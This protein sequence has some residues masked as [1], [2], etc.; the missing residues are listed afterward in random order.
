[1]F[2]TYVVTLCSRQLYV[3]S[4]DCVGYAHPVTH[5]PEQTAQTSRGRSSTR[6][7][8]P[9]R[10]LLLGSQQ[11]TH[12]RN[13]LAWEM[14]ELE[15]LSRTCGYEPVAHETIT[16]AA[17]HAATLFGKGTIERIA[18]LI[19]QEQIAT[20]IVNDAL[21]PR[22]QRNLEEAWHVTVLDRTEV[23]LEI[24][25]HRATTAEG[26]IQVEMAQLEHM[27]PRLAGGWTHLERQRG[28]VGLRGGPGE[29]QIEVD[30]RLVRNRLKKL[31]KQLE[32][33]TR[34]RT[35]RRA[36]RT[37]VPLA[38]CAFVGY[39]NAGKSTLLNALTHAT[40]FADDQL[41]ATLDPT[42]RMMQF[43]S[44][45]RV[46]VTDTV[47]FIQNLPTELVEAFASTLEEVSAAS[48]HCIVLDGS[49]PDALS[50]LATVEATLDDMLCTQPRI[51][52]ANKC[53]LLD[54]DQRN[55]VLSTL[56][57]QVEY[58]LIPISAAT[59]E[60]LKEVKSAI[61]QEAG[62]LVPETLANR[63]YQGPDQT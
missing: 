17:P 16:L 18:D 10:V 38:T 8:E 31:K 37:S 9:I 57:S 47:G 51:L 19:I 21:L 13:Q 24:F 35:V 53:D 59:G 11:R 2:Y 40:V 12:A 5:D 32:A 48:L 60:G 20:V 39:T 58:P 28:G 15:E 1:M 34:Q 7:T 41:F 30:R 55:N 27:L 46:I 61:D 29:Q 45:R 36:A 43:A 26:R 3:A 42:S 54:P 56:R 62:T 25:A 63:P 4:P 23:I 50:Q 22:Q 6:T 49:H 33:L 52:I 14:E 44:G